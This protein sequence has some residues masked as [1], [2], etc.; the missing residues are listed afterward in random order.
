ME[1]IEGRMGK[2]ECDGDKGEM[3]A[4]GGSDYIGGK[5]RSW[6]QRELRKGID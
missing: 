1:R 6:E 5:A 4:G 2:K 3:K